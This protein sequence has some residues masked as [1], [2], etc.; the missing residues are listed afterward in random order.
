MDKRGE[1]GRVDRTIWY[2][3][4]SFAQLNFPQS[5]V[6]EPNNSNV[7]AVTVSGNLYE[8]KNTTD[9]RREASVLPTLRHISAWKS[10]SVTGKTLTYRVFMMNL[11]HSDHQLSGPRLQW[12][13][14]QK[15]ASIP[16]S[17]SDSFHFKNLTS[18]LSRMFGGSGSQSHH[19]ITESIWL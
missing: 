14:L 6:T 12:T 1:R 16:T 11:S 8:E 10:A 13:F 3:H 17:E 9:I 18:S 15:T 4:R 5:N 7:V 19:I 2:L